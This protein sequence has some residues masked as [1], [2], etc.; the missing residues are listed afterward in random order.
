M[1]PVI[2]ATVGKIDPADECNVM[3]RRWTANHDQFLM[4]AAAATNTLI[5]ECRG[6]SNVDR[7]NE[8]HVLAF[9]EAKLRRMRAPEQSV[10]RRVT[11][12]RANQTLG[13]RHSLIRNPLVRV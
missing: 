7:F 10:H 4:M 8:L 3:I 5:D 2:T 1:L 13:D 6:A 12:Q 11:S 9:A